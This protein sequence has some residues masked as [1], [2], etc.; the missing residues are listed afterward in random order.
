MPLV[1]EL[2]GYAS[3]RHSLLTD[4]PPSSSFSKNVSLE[5]MGTTEKIGVITTKIPTVA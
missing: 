2:F 1:L 3:H 5:H 4:N